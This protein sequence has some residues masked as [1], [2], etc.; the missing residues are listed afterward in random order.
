MMMTCSDLLLEDDLIL[1]QQVTAGQ[2][3]FCPHAAA[4]NVCLY[5][6]TQNAALLKPFPGL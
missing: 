6:I 2:G 1:Q 5:S 3:W 4:G